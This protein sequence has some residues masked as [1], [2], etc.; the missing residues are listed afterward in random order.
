MS[1]GFSESVVNDATLGWLQALGYALHHRPD[2][3]AG[4]HAAERIL[5]GA[6]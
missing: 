5:K 6:Q 3:A 1:D 2:I 4:K